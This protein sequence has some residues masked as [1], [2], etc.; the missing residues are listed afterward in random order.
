M[1]P[2]IEKVALMLG[3][4]KGNIQ[5]NFETAQ[6][7]LHEKAGKIEMLSSVYNSEPWGLAAQPE[8]K[9]Q[10]IIL[11]TAL[12]PEALLEVCNEIETQIGK[13]KEEVNGPRAIDI[14]ILLYSDKVIQSP[15]L[16]IPHPRLHLRKFNLLPLTEIAP[17]WIHPVMQ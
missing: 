11:C 16:T 14:D 7:M 6:R 1:R 9:N 13:N 12:S 4:N 8:F 3:G 15:G 10:A 2:A 17:E 5:L